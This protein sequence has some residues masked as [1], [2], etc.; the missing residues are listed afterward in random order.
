MHYS[1]RM[2]DAGLSISVAEASEDLMKCLLLLVLCGTIS[3]SAYA[4][5][6]NSKIADLSQMLALAD[7]E[8]ESFNDEELEIPD[9]LFDPSVQAEINNLEKAADQE[10]DPVSQIM[11]Q[12]DQKNPQKIPVEKVEKIPV[13]LWEEDGVLYGSNNEEQTRQRVVI[14]VEV[15][16]FHGNHLFSQSALK[17]IVQTVSDYFR[18]QNLDLAND[19]VA[20]G[21]PGVEVAQDMDSKEPES[22]G[23]GTDQKTYPISK[24]VFQYDQE[25][26]KHI[27]IEELENVSVQLWEKDGVLYGKESDSRKSVE[28]TVGDINHSGKS[29]LFTQSA[30]QAIIQS[31][32]AYFHDR[33]INWVMVYIPSDEIGKYG[34]DLR[35]A[36]DTTLAIS[37]STPVVKGTSVSFADP[38]RS[39]SKLTQK[40][41]DN[42]PASLPDPSTGYPGDFINSN[43][44]NNYLHALNRHSERRVDL[45]IGPTALPGEVAFDFVVTQNRPYHFYVNANNNVPKPIH[46]WQESVGFIQT[47]LSGNDDILKL[48]ASSDSFDQFY[49]VDASYEAPFGKSIKHRW[50]ISGSFSRFISAEFALPQNLFV[51]TQTIGN[52]EIISNVWQ[53]GKLFLDLVIDLQYRHIHNHGHFL[54]SSATK[55]FILPAIGL[56]AIRLKRESKF[57]ASLSVQST[58]SSLFWDVSHNLEDLGR[59]DPSKNWAIVQGGLYGSF[60]LEPF[61]P[62]YTKQLINEIVFMG[63]FQTAFNQRLIPQLEGILGGLYTVRGYPQST[64]A[65]DNLYLGSLDY[66]IHIPGFLAPRSNGSVCLFGKKL[67]WAPAQCGGDVDWDFIIRGFLDAGG[68]TV[69]HPILFEKNYFI[70]GTG[71]GAELVVWHN[72]FLRADWGMALR[73]A[74]GISSGNQQWY[75]SAT[76]VF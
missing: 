49:T 53:K 67:R 35:S 28:M 37:I 33:D 47:Q 10:N 70:M 20:S 31:T 65:G 46:R 43:A 56:K 38:S 5:E 15:N 74:N 19:A 42:L 58:M 48:D 51:G 75:G 13:T 36:Q 39:N 6:P 4:S 64:I 2:E 54:F 68:T 59:L 29:M 45:E 16:N 8:M 72:I 55:N 63:Q 18:A 9:E 27:G 1:D 14:L 26:P 22:A 34:T 57:I 23:Q 30:L 41:Y 60:Y 21:E 73:S 24:I 50:Q 71:A 62:N 40:I 3:A 11:I 7:Q 32:F 17:Q 61:F 12:Y 52:L 69:N 25:H 44:L 76:V 66:R